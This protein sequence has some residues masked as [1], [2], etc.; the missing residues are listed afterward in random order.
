MIYWNRTDL[1]L[2]TMI[3]LL[4]LPRTHECKMSGRGPMD[5]FGF[6]VFGSRVCDYE[7]TDEYRGPGTAFGVFIF[8]GKF[9]SSG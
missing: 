2:T 3:V 7:V 9:C 8:R 1:G 5:G 6:D 4:T